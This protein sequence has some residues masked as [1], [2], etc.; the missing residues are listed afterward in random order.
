MVVGIVSSAWRFAGGSTLREVVRA[1]FRAVPERLNLLV[2]RR[3]RLDLPAQIGGVGASPGVRRNPQIR[4][5]TQRSG[6]PLPCPPGN[7][8]GVPAFGAGPRVFLGPPREPHAT[9]VATRR[10]PVKRLPRRRGQSG[11]SAGRADDAG[12]LHTPAPLPS[13][14]RQQAGS[15]RPAMRSWGYDQGGLSGLE[16][17]ASSLTVSAAAKAAR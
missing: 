5:H 16:P 3:D 8:P 17:P 4:E 10:G 11:R 1:A 12:Q 2:L 9:I 13:V 6:A 7:L 15:P 14:S